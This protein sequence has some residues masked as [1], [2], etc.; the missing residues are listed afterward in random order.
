MAPGAYQAR[1]V[2]INGVDVSVHRASISSVISHVPCLGQH[3]EAKRRAG[4]GMDDLSASG[5]PAVWGGDG[6]GDREDVDRR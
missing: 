1:I 2:N 4:Q 5:P 3:D 6:Y